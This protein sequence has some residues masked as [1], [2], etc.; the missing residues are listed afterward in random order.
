MA[1]PPLTIVIELRCAYCGLDH[2]VQVKV[3]PVY[4]DQPLVQAT[5]L[6]EGIDVLHWHSTTSIIEP[7]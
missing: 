5:A 7:E 3:R 6:T 4:G 2:R 1:V